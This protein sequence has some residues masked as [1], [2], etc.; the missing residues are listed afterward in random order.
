MT[1]YQLFVECHRGL[2]WG[3][4]PCLFVIYIDDSV[5]SQ[6]LKFADDTKITASISSAEE[7][8]ILQKDL[9]RLMEWSEEWQMKFNVNKC[10][11]MHLGYNHPSYE[12]SMIGEVL[13]DTEEERDLGVKKANQM[14]GM[15][16]RY[17]HYK[18]RKTMLLLYKSVVRP[19]L[20]Y[21]VQ[22]W[23]PNKISDIKL[24]EGDQRRFTKCIPELNTLPYEMRLKNLNLAT[25]ETRRIRGDL[26]EVYRIMNG[27]EAIDWKL[28]FSKAPYDGTRGHT[29]K[30]ENKVIRLDIRKYFF[31]QR[32]IDYRNTLPQTAIDAKKY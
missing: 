24:L 14:L 5:S 31:S 22:V 26:T 25:L 6:I 27:I 20:E 15:I 7:Q 16:R 4:G 8:H 29:M 17:F 12:Y 13:I 19:H 10:K 9:T 11:V 28:I 18:D 32:V 23:C 3:M 1:G 2:L 30:L 21:A